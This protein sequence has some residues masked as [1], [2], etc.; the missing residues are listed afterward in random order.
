MVRPKKPKAE[1]KG[2]TF[3]FRV[4]EEMHKAFVHAAEIDGID[5]SAFVR[6]AAILRAREL[7]VKI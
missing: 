6:R 5:L 4:T 1:R 3:R 2:F 7:G